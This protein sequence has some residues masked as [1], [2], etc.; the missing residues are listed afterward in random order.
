MIEL[1]MTEQDV[2]RIRFAVSPV[3]ETLAAVRAVNRGPLPPALGPWRRLV[4]PPATPVLV[5]V[6]S[7]G[8]YTPDFLTPPPQAGERSIAAEIEQVAKTPLEVVRDELRRT[9]APLHGRPE[10]LR[11]RI[12]QEL[13]IAWSVLLEPHWPRLHRVL[14]TDVDHRSRQLVGGGIAGLLEDL[15][16]RVEWHDGTLRVRGAV[17]DRRDLHGEGV[18]LM[19]SAFGTDKPLVILDPP[20]QPTLIYPARGV[21]TAF[22]APV[23]PADALVRLMGSGRAELLAV[24]DEPAGTGELALLVARTAGTVSEHLHALRAAGLVEVTRVGKSV[25]WHRTPLGNALVSGPLS[26]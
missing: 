21:A 3:W 8:G 1:R 13:E 17:R 4:T 19:P 11:K 2:L 24:L 5:A 16:P 14:A 23:A 12:V 22:T 26:A 18:V 9:G 15:H 6:Q 10:S 25:R 20:Y 7:N